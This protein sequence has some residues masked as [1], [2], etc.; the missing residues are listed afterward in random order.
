MKDWTLK[1]SQGQGTGTKKV[2]GRMLSYLIPE[3]RPCYKRWA[4]EDG[5]MGLKNRGRQQGG[6]GEE[7][8]LTCREGNMSF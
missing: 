8:R 7:S 1:L 2:R 3:T 5:R 6:T 4:H